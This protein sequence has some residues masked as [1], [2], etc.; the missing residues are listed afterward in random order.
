MQR[1]EGIYGQRMPAA[2]CAVVTDR[3]TQLEEMEAAY[4][5]AQV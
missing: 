2:L 1:I 3:V 4:T 5:Q